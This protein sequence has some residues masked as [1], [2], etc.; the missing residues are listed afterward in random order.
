MKEIKTISQN[1]Y[2]LGEGITS[3]Q[4]RTGLGEVVDLSVE[5]SKLTAALKGTPLK[6]SSALKESTSIEE[7][8]A[9]K[10]VGVFAVKD[11]I[12]EFVKAP[13]RITAAFKREICPLYDPV[14]PGVYV[15][16]I[17]FGNRIPKPQICPRHDPA[18]ILK[19]DIL[20]IKKKTI[21]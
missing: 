19:Q 14:S 3:A 17:K 11:N 10:V 9:G 13:S 8:L 4:I 20:E 16:C 21:K 18:P 15:P 12:L 1:S 6:L 7:I 2:I 5:S